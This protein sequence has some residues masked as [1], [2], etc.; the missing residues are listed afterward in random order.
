MNSFAPTPE[1]LW[2]IDF[3]IAME[4]E[5]LRLT[6]LNWASDMEEEI[7]FHYCDGP[8]SGE[9]DPLAETLA[10]ADYEMEYDG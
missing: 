6:T 9:P 2:T 8:V 3:E 7:A 1:Y 10:A 5:F 4:E